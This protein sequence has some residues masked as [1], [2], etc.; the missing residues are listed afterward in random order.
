[1]EIELMRK[2]LIYGVLVLSTLGTLNTQA[3]GN[4]LPKCKSNVCEQLE[5]KT[6]SLCEA[7]EETHIPLVDQ[8]SNVACACDCMTLHEQDLVQMAELSQIGEIRSL[9]VL[10]VVTAKSN[11]YDDVEGPFNYSVPDGWFIRNASFFQEYRDG[12]AG[13]NFWE[14]GGSPKLLTWRQ[15]NHAYDHAQEVLFQTLNKVAVAA[16]IKKQLQKEIGH[17]LEKKRKQ[18]LA[19]RSKAAKKAFGELRY[20][21]YAEGSWRGGSEIRGYPVVTIQY[22]GHDVELLKQ[23]LE[24]FVQNEVAKRGG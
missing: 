20:S 5:P 13:I 10:P 24:K 18:H 19:A 1:M 11:R 15:I 12:N 16:G 14:L 23:V 3:Q 21:L 7:R 6:Y 8:D 4:W 17:R 9:D 2:T 22:I